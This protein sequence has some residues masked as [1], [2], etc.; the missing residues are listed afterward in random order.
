MSFTHRRE[1]TEWVE[2]AKKAETRA[3]RVTQTLERL[4]AS[5]AKR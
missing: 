2:G 4:R 1:Y 5:A 3:C